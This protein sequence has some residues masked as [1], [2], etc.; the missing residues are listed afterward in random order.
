MPSGYAATLT[1]LLSRASLP[2]Y[3]LTLTEQLDHLTRPSPVELHLSHTL[4]RERDSKQPYAFPR[5]EHL[6][7][8]SLSVLN[9]IYTFNVIVG[10]LILRWPGN[11]LVILS[12]QLALNSTVV[13]VQDS[14]IHF[15]NDHAGS[16]GYLATA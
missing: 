9:E 7:L 6:R 11:Y 2:S 15:Y 4:I 8:A 16:N 14:Y 13:L 1:G 5:H 10:L 3:T 12:S